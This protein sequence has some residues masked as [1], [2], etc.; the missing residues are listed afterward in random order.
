MNN[1]EFKLAEL[2]AMR[3]Q[4]LSRVL[5]ESSFMERNLRGAASPDR[6]GFSGS[7]RTYLLHAAS[8]IK[9]AHDVLSL[10]LDEEE[11]G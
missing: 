2:S 8:F 3:K 9:Q 11:I 7:Q 1:D 6:K 4:W 5:H 10:V